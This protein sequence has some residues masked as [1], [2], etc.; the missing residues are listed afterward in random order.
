MREQMKELPR[1][2]EGCLEAGG[3]ACVVTIR[4]A[5]RFRA[6]F[7][8]AEEQAQAATAPERNEEGSED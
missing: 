1:D 7:P 2:M 8:A 4:W 3:E 5:G 6:S